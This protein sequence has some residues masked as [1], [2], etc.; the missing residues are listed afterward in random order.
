V[1]YSN[2]AIKVLYNEFIQLYDMS[3]FI[4]IRQDKSNKGL[5]LYSEH[6]LDITFDPAGPIYKYVR[7]TL[8]YV[9][10]ASQP[11]SVLVTISDPL[12]PEGQAGVTSYSLDNPT[13][14]SMFQAVDERTTLEVSNL[15]EGT[16]LWAMVPNSNVL[17]VRLMV[18][19]LMNRTDKSQVTSYISYDGCGTAITG[20]TFGLHTY[21]AW[22]SI[23]NPRLTTN[24]F[25]LQGSPLNWTVGT[26]AGFHPVPHSGKELFLF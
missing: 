20:Y 1:K 19:F 3:Y 13:V 14:A 12:A 6:C 16:N 17:R 23:V 21:S 15:G 25:A 22:D 7:L 8:D 11:D 18:G 5:Y 26:N 24:L 4:P 2:Q 9:A 10:N